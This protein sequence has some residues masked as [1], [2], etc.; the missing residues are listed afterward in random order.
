[1]KKA[2]KFPLEVQEG[3]NPEPDSTESSTPAWTNADK[4]RFH[5]GRPRTIGG[6]TAAQ[7][8]SGSISGCPRS[9][10]SYFY[11]S[12]FRYIIGTDEKLYEYINTS[13]TNITPFKAGTT[14]IAGDITSNFD[15]LGNDPLLILSLTYPYVL[16]VDYT[17]ADG[18]LEVGD[19]ITIAGVGAGTYFGSVDAGDINGDHIVKYVFANSVNVWIDT[20]AISTGQE[21]GASVTVGTGVL[22][23]DVG[24]A[25]GLAEG[26]RILISGAVTFDGITDTSIN[27]EHVIRNVAANTFD[28]A[29]TD[30]STSASASGTPPAYQE[31][32]D[33]GSCDKKLGAGYGGAKYGV[34]KYSVS[35]DFTALFTLPSIWSQA[36]YGNDIVLTRGGQTGVYLYD[37]VGKKT[38]CTFNHQAVVSDDEG[39]TDDEQRPGQSS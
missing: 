33:V 1:M 16:N 15:S 22:N 17:G 10:F 31:E 12:K 23:C 27:V 28:I 20:D 24:S 32:L 11:N 14:S 25:H 39:D 29:I 37:G 6:R 38:N 18:I 8:D 4:M 2:R 35:K 9:I 5:N 26:D 36:R 19:T 3:I 7:I 30:T 13:L 34:G 21:G